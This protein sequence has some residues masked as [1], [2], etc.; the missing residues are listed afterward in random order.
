[1]SDAFEAELFQ[2]E[3]PA[4]W[5]F[6]RVPDDRAPDFAGAFGRVPVH[7][8]VDGVAWPTSVWRDKSH[9]WLLA[10]PRRVRQDKGDGDVVRVCVDV[11][12]SRI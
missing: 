8:T 11:D 4:A 3:G 12:E 1:M 5:M 7:A 6:V 2:W 10:V 9:G